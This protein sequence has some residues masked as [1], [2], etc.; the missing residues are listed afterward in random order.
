MGVS[1]LAD[2][3]SGPVASSNFKRLARLHLEGGGQV[4]VQGDYA[5]IGHMQPPHGTTIVNIS[6]PVKPEIVSHIQLPDMYSHS[7]KVRVVGDLMIVNSEQN[8]RHFLRKGCEI[9]A[10]SRQL[11]QEL[12]RE[13]NDGEIAARLGVGESQ[14][15]TLREAAARGYDDGG[16]KIYDISDKTS[17][18]LIK[19][20]K[21]YGVGV[22]RFDCDQRYAY[23]STEKEGFHGNILSI[24]D[25]ENP[26]QPEEISNWWMPGQHLAGGDTPHWTGYRNRLHHTMKLRDRIYAS[27]WHAGFAIIDASD[28]ASPVTLATHDY[29]PPV[30]E[31]THT[32]MP[33]PHPIEGRELA[34]VIDEEHEHTH[35][36]PHA[37]MWLFDI[38]DLNNIH[39]L[40]SFHVS[41]ADSPWSRSGLRFGAH[42]FQEHLSGTLVFVTWFSAGLRVVDIKNPLLPEEVGYFIPEPG[43]GHA[44]PQ[45][46]D[47]E[48]DGRGLVYLLD[49]LNGLDILEFNG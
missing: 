1:K 24:Y 30:L 10:I 49:R 43:Q 8:D 19:F 37:C 23:I 32:I 38:G 2:Q 45:S 22:H 29:H 26:E 14:L 4:V 44:L 25:L 3:S 40:S 17:P 11:E 48:V 15:P 20:Q 27:C 13:P 21:T 6:D 31:P 9:A 39:A 46:N 5:Y 35:G 36:Q 41:E 7:H 47:V 16:F 42:Q 34:L 33:V 12:G 18:R 28:I